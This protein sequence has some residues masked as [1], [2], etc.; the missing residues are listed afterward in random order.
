[1]LILKYRICIA[2]MMKR[3]WEIRLVLCGEKRQNF[4]KALSLY[5]CLMQCAG[6]SRDVTDEVFHGTYFITVNGTP[7]AHLVL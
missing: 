7:A 6:L 5:S 3:T 1:M 2:I 4:A